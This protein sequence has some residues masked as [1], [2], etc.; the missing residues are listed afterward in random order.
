[1]ISRPLHQTADE[2][3]ERR[4]ERRQRV[5]D[6]RRHLRVHRPRDEAV[7]LHPAQRHGQHPLADSVDSPSDLVEAQRAGVAEHVDDVDR[8]FVSDAGEDVAGMTVRGRI[9][10]LG[11]PLD[12]RFS[13]WLLRGISGTLACVLFH[14]KRSP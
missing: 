2:L 10:Q 6:A 7:A 12:G 14:R 9:L 5:L 13:H 3:P 4:A 1:M 11:R 8:P